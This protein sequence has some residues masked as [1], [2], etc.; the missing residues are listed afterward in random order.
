MDEFLPSYEQ[1]TLNLP[2]ANRNRAR[3]AQPSSSF[4]GSSSSRQ[5]GSSEIPKTIVESFDSHPPSLYPNLNDIEG[6]ENGRK[7][8]KKR[9]LSA[10]PQHPIEFMEEWEAG[11]GVHTGLFKSLSK[12]VD[13]GG[14]TEWK[15]GK[16]DL[17][18]ETQHIFI[19]DA[20]GS[21]KTAPFT[22]SIKHASVIVDKTTLKKPFVLLLG[23]MNGK[24]LRVAF[25]SKETMN[26]LYQALK[27][28][29]K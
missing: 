4:S 28:S 5:R 18:S 16:I 13:T 3:T 6:I 25:D 8:P 27:E 26:D 22:I 19:R 1:I 24:K 7:P 14:S 29:T 2:I 21:G 17:V 10:L 15:K 11:H 9:I 20:S 23:L 12:L